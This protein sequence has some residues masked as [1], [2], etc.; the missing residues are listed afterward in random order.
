MTF[1]RDAVLRSVSNVRCGTNLDIIINAF[2]GLLTRSTSEKHVE[3]RGR[4]PGFPAWVR[5]VM[6][7]TFGEII[8]V[9]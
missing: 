5:S 7:L 9:L 1:L 8:A 4:A 6:R 2:R 3:R